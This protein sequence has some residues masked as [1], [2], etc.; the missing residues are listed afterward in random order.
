VIESDR[1]LSGAYFGEHGGSVIAEGGVGMDL[2]HE[3]RE[4][5]GGV[6]LVNGFVEGDESVFDGAWA[7]DGEQGGDGAFTGGETVGL[8][9]LEGGDVGPGGPDGGLGDGDFLRG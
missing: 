2:L 5:A 6:V 1:G 4:I 3:S 9:F 8:D 7:C